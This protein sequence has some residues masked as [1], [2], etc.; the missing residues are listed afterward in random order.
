MHIF[1][2]ACK[3]FFMYSDEHKVSGMGAE[4]FSISQ[5]DNF[6]RRLSSSTQ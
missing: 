6:F 2:V 5:I 4:S 1:V 3:L